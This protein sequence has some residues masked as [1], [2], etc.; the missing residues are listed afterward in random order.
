MTDD[1]DRSLVPLADATLALA[2]PE[3]GSVLSKMVC[4]TL[5]LARRVPLFKIGEYEWCEPDYRQILLWAQQLALEPEEVIRR[6]MDRRSLHRP[7]M[8]SRVYQ[9]TV[10]ENGRIVKLNWDFAL[11]PLAVFEWVEDLDID[12]LRVVSSQYDPN[13]TPVL[14]LSLPRLR[15]LICSAVPLSE[16]DLSHVPCLEILNCSHNRLTVLDLSHVPM[17]TELSCQDNGLT[18]LDVSHTRRLTTLGCFGNK[19]TELDLSNLSELTWLACGQN[20][21]TTLELSS[22]PNLREL[23]CNNNRLR[24]LDL[25]FG[26]EL[27]SLDC[28]HNL[29]ERLHLEDAYIDDTKM[30]CDGWVY[31]SRYDPTYGSVGNGAIGVLPREV[32]ERLRT[33]KTQPESACGDYEAYLNLH[34]YTS[35]PR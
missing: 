6:L 33:D 32:F 10:F 19:L 15:E 11:L 25:S 34:G 7:D 22:V 18:G 27:E 30:E 4:E 20:N 26:S 2:R 13:A 28:R 17:L 3:A 23:Y 31:V 21:L 8:D 16:L 35:R 5:T 24:K 14:K 1:E 12:Y 29:I 9:E